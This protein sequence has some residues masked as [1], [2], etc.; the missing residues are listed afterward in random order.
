MQPAQQARPAGLGALAV[1][2]DELLCYLLHGLEVRELL[3]LSQ[4]SRLLRLLVCE[5]PIWLKLHLDRCARP[6]EYRVRAGCVIGGLSYRWGTGCAP[7]GRRRL[8][9]RLNRRLD[10]R[11]P[12]QLEPTG[13]PEIA[14]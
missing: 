1:L 13:L 8:N 6:F 3:A 2:S 14:C 4:A 9:R 12:R 10:R 11:G 7:S 5:E